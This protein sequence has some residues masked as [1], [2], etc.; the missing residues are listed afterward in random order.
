MLFVRVRPA[1]LAMCIVFATGCGNADPAG[2]ARPAAEAT[3]VGTPASA[4]ASRFPERHARRLERAFADADSG[5]SPTNACAVVAGLVAG[6]P[7]PAGGTVNP[8]SVA[9]FEACYVDASVRYLHRL[10]EEAAGD[11]SPDSAEQL[12]LRG[13]SHLLISRTSIGSMAKN[14]DLDPVDLGRRIADRLP[15]GLL[16]RCPSIMDVAG[17]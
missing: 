16:E 14:L 17:A 5:K 4:A 13:A 2:G 1:L 9:A 10:T 15:P 3:T 11:A 8:D 6:T 12:C 7:P